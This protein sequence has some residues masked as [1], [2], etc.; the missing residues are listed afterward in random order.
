MSK[1]KNCYNIS[2]ARTKKI[3]WACKKRER[4]KYG[5]RIGKKKKKETRMT[6]RKNICTSTQ[7]QGEKK[8]VTIVVRQ[9]YIDVFLPKGDSS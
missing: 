7:F 8:H 4:E 2:D 1:R 9:E 3:E 5:M 6:R